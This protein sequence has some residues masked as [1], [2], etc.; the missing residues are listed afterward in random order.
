MP[1]ILPST[2]DNLRLVAGILETG[3]FVVV[4]TDTVYGIGCNACCSDAVEEVFRIKNRP[5]TLPISVCYLNLERAA[6]DLEINDAAEVFVRKFLPGPVTVVLKKRPSSCVS[7][8]CSSGKNSLGLRIIAN[9]VLQKLLA[10]LPFPLALTSANVSGGSNPTT[11]QES[12]ISLE[13][14]ENLIVLDGGRCQLGTESTVVDLTS[15]ALKILRV[16]AV[17]A[18]CLC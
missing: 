3:G 9:P 7:S 16:G 11:A 17:A 12:C 5:K 13:K 2:D 14:A 8:L 1:K 18:D 15:G 4:P 10:K 6:S